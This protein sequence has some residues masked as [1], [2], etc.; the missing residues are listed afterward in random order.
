MAVTTAAGIPPP[1][2]PILGY[3]ACPH[4][5]AVVPGRVFVAHP[6]RNRGLR[7]CLVKVR[8]SLS[9]RKQPTRIDFYYADRDLKTQ[10]QLCKI[11]Q[12]IR[13]SEACL[14]DF[15]GRNANVAI[16]FGLAVGKGINGIVVFSK[17]DRN[18]L[19][20]DL[21]G[22]GRIEFTGYPDLVSQLKEK[23]PQFLGEMR[24]RIAVASSPAA[25]RRAAKPAVK[26]SRLRTDFP[27]RSVDLASWRQEQGKPPMIRQDDGLWVEWDGAVG[28]TTSGNLTL[29]N[30]LPE[31]FE[32]EAVL[33][34]HAFG[35]GWDPGVY[36]YAGD[37]VD[38][39]L[40]A[41]LMPA[42]PPWG[43][44]NPIG[45]I[46]TPR[47]AGEVGRLNFNHF[48]TVPVAPDKPVRII[49]TV[50]S[51]IAEAAIGDREAREL[52]LPSRPTQLVL[53]AFRWSAEKAHVMGQSARYCISVFSYR[54]LPPN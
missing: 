11:C 48:L 2:C 14:F 10:Q 51:G 49:L 54:E 34:G 37:G 23:L 45:V 18:T 20:S 7:G 5:V 21:A 52:P 26:P 12:Q 30:P 4:A 3:A 25:T 28:Y 35:I 40:G 29:R 44:P 42:V 33:T 38:M 27:G 53:G 31:A 22:L 13:S 39:V 9:R 8:S 1:G 50:R 41:N 43:I 19:P 47:L 17:R 46:R 36:L 15:R 24:K 6:Y 16:E 32:V